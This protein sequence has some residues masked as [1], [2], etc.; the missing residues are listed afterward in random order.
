[1]SRESSAG[2]AIDSRNLRHVPTYLLLPMLLMLLDVVCKVTMVVGD[3]GWV[4]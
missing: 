4:D 1:M 3:M 2:C